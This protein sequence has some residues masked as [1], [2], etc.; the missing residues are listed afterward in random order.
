MHNLLFYRFLL[1]NVLLACLAGALWLQGYVWPVIEGGAPISYI[2]L[3]LFAVGWAWSAKEIVVISADLNE[4]KRNGITP[5]LLAHADK[6]AAKVEWLGSVAEWL[7]ALGLIGTVLGFMVA[8]SGIADATSADGA[9]K[10][11]A[12]LGEGMNLALTTTLLGASLAIWM[13]INVR[14]LKTGMAVYWSDRLAANQGSGAVR[15]AD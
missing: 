13:E 5:A 12:H 8:L 7:A 15:G 4:S 3:G 6:D 1:T 11:V 9:L 2:I 14:L 10:A